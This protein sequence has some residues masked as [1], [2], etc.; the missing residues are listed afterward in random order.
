MDVS[1]T[2]LPDHP[3]TYGSANHS[4]QPLLAQVFLSKVT[5]APSERG[6]A[7]RPFC[8]ASIWP[9]VRLSMVQPSTFA[10][11]YMDC[12][13]PAKLRPAPTAARAALHGRRCAPPDSPTTSTGRAMPAPC[14]A[15]HMHGQRIHAHASCSSAHSDIVSRRRCPA[16]VRRRRRVAPVSRAAA[17]QDDDAASSA[18]AP[19][20][21][22]PPAARFGSE[23]AEREGTFSPQ[24]VSGN[25]R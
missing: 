4:I 25:S 8:S 18:P 20:P 11:I 2:G 6:A 13:H 5:R 16:V 21:P 22:P 14:L 1:A 10:S 15:A 3:S 19:T 9:P 17:S 12:A 7:A 23:I 24:R